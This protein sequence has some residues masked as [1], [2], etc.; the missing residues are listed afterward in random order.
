MGHVVLDHND[1]FSLSSMTSRAH[2]AL[3]TLTSWLGMLSSEPNSLLHP[4]Q[5]IYDHTKYNQAG[6]CWCSLIGGVWMAIK[7]S[8]ESSA[9][10]SCPSLWAVCNSAPAAHVSGDAKYIWF[11]RLTGEETPYCGYGEVFIQA[12]GRLEWCSCLGL[13][14]L[15]DVIPHSCYY[16]QVQ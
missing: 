6:A 13:P 4:H 5:I 1:C 8:Y 11:G 7:H 14:T 12:G 15:L 2:L 3:P 16:R 9:T 10:P